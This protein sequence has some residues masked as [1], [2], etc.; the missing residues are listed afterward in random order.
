M[1]VRSYMRIRCM[2]NKETEVTQTWRPTDEMIRVLEEA[3]DPDNNAFISTWFK[4]AGVDR[5]K[6]YD[7]NKKPMFVSWWNEEWKKGMERLEPYL[8]KIGLIKAMKDYRYFEAMQ[9][10]YHKFSR[11]EEVKTESEDKLII[12]LREDGE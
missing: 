5:T 1:G 4:K 3:L 11:R 7:W 9:M 8:D 6:W 10:K 2:E 12:D